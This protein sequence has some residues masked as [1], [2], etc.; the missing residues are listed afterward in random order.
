MSAASRSARARR[1]ERMTPKV[2]RPTRWSAP[3]RASRE[4]SAATRQARSP[5]NRTDR[6]AP[7][8]PSAP[9]RGRPQA[10]PELPG[11]RRWVN[12][13][14]FRVAPPTLTRRRSKRSCRSSR[15]CAHK[16]SATRRA[17]LWRRCPR[18]ASGIPRPA[19]HLRRRHPYRPGP[20]RH[21]ALRR[22]RDHKSGLDAEATAP[23]DRAPPADSAVG[24]V[25]VRCGLVAHGAKPAAHP[26]L[27]ADPAAW[28]G[29]VDQGL[30]LQR[31][32]GQRRMAFVR[33]RA[34]RAARSCCRTEP[35]RRE[36]GPGEVC[37]LTFSP[38]SARRRDSTTTPAGSAPIGAVA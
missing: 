19:L 14:I 23:A 24:L 27:L 1:R 15:I 13:R 33:A 16:A 7:R 37:G 11:V 17:L 18:P 21:R 20:A 35:S 3:T 30:A 29:A 2:K 8:E 38:R 28:P 26:A 6:S 32:Q 25:A 31:R 22:T 9:A 12:G 36:L 4:L 10:S 34:R 5:E